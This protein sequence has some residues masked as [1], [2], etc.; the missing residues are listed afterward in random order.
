MKTH[1]TTLLALLLSTALAAGEAIAGDPVRHSG[2][3]SAHSAMAVGES[4]LA[5]AKLVAGAVA[6]PLMLSGGVGALSGEAGS[7]LWHAA[8]GSIGEP[9]PIAEETYITT[10][11]PRDA[12]AD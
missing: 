5:G 9:L 6:V 8:G 3:A 7:S 2:Q 1:T 12:M 11:S 4:T 10:P